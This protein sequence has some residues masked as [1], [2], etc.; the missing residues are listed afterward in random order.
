M[1]HTMKNIKTF[2]SIPLDSYFRIGREMEPYLKVSSTYYKHIRSDVSYYYKA[3][4]EKYLKVFHLTPSAIS[5]GLTGKE[6]RLHEEERSWILY[7]G[8]RKT[9]ETKRE[10]MTRIETQ[11]I[12]LVIWELCDNPDFQWEAVKA[13][14]EDIDARAWVAKKER[15]NPND[16]GSYYI[17][18][19]DLV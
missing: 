3:I 11:Q 7:H 4:E 10:P 17:E 8:E 16:R 13:F 5:I 14:S 1:H 6:G 18:K 9:E 19:M 2:K 12:Y 15:L